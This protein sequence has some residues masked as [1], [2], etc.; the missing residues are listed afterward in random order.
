MLHLKLRALTPMGVDP[1]RRADMFIEFFVKGRR[2]DAVARFMR[3][4]VAGKGDDARVRREVG[5]APP[6]GWEA[7]HH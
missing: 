7:R 2:P 3:V 5:R 6:I 1:W 4:W